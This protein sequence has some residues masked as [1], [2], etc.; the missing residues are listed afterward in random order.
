MWIRSLRESKTNPFE[1]VWFWWFITLM[2]KNCY[3]K[4]IVMEN[5]DSVKKYLVCKR[6][7]SLY[8]KVTIIKS[9][10]VPK[11]VYVSSLLTTPGGVIQELNRLIFKFFWKGVDKVT[12]LSVINDYEKSGLKMIDLKTM[13]KSLRIAWLKEIFSGNNGTWKNYLRHLLKPF[14]DFF[15]FHFNYNVKDLTISSQFYSGALAARRAAKRS[16]IIIEKGTTRM[17]RNRNPCNSFLM[18]KMASGMD[19]DGDDERRRT[20]WRPSS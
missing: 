6:S 5:P 19:H 20:T 2:I 9:L 7:L 15:L 12:R 1:P 16:P 4:K 3:S 17:H 14:G 10:I 8:G 13:V 18:V 11:F